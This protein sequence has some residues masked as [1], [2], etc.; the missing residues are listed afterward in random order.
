MGIYVNPRHSGYESTRKSQ[1]FVDKSEMLQFTNSILNTSRKYCCVSCPRRFGKTTNAAMLS[2]YYSAGCDSAS[3]FDDLRI[4]SCPDYPLHLNRYPLIFLD[5]Q[6]FRSVYASS[7][8]GDPDFVGLLPFLQRRIL[9][10]LSRTFPDVLSLPSGKFDIDED[11]NLANAI[12]EIHLEKDVQFVFIIDEWDCFFREDKNNIDLQNEYINLLRSLFKGNAADRCVLL[13]YMTGI[14]PIKKYDTQSALNN[15]TEYTMIRPAECAPYMGF[16]EAEVRALCK[17]S[18]GDSEK[19]RQWYDGY[20]LPGIGSVYNPVSVLEALASGVIDNYW[21]RTAS[22]EDLKRYINLDFDGVRKAIVQLLGG[23]PVAADSG[24]FQNDLT[25]LSNR[26]DILTLLVHLG[27]LSWQQ[28]PEQQYG[29]VRIPNREIRSVFRNAVKDIRWKA[30]SDALERSSSLL[31]ATWNQDE[32]QVAKEIEQ[33]HEDTSSLF[34][35]N[36]EDSL[37]CVIRLAYY[38]A[39]SY[40]DMIQEFPAGKGRA[41]VVFLPKPHSGRIAMIIELKWNHSTKT[42][43]RQ[44]KDLNYSGKLKAYQEVLLV[45]INYSE[46]TRKHTCLIEKWKF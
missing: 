26:D 44:I 27:Y 15:F 16:S 29:M 8:K 21:A 42:A 37:R 19:I 22:F 34:D 40:Y 45:G 9:Q 28:V 35:Y 14:L 23:E 46:K 1:L 25:T 38:T 5:I 20:K 32:E 3:L 17:K 11:T 39:Q 18:G 6:H 4:A 33:V 31:T 13:A 2:A 24:S 10:E 30:I 43:I 12:L 36:S 7:C 41:D